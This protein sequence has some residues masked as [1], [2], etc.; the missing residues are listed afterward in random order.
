M[1]KLAKVGVEGFRVG[2]EGGRVRREQVRTGVELK[3][4]LEELD[5]KQ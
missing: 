4:V 2:A 1:L 5:Q 3:Q